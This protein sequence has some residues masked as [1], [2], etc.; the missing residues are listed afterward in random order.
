MKQL[1]LLPF[2]LLAFVAQAQ[3]EPEFE[4]E[5]DSTSNRFTALNSLYLEIGN[6]SDVYSINYDRIVYTHNSFKACCT[7]RLWNQHVFSGK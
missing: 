5:S 2:L 6:N 7:Y 3:E 4:F 1:L